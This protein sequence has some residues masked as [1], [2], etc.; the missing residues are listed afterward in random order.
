MTLENIFAQ[1]PNGKHTLRVRATFRPT[2]TATL[3]P[4]ALAFVGTTHTFSYGWEIEPDDG[5][6][7]Y[8]GMVAWVPPDELAGSGLGWVPSCDLVP[9][10]DALEITHAE[11]CQCACHS[12]AIMHFVECECCAPGSGVAP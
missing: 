7:A 3:R 4:E 5:F 10:D 11:A 9:V 8:Q 2:I 12:G 6:P 1:M